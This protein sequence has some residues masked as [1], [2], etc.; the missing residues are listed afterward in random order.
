MRLH[1]PTFASFLLLTAA[2]VAHADPNALWNIVHGKCVVDTAP[3]VSVN[4]EEHFALLK[5]QRGV[6]QHLLI[7]TER[8]TGIEDKALLDPATP[9]FFAD[10][11][12]EKQAVDAK[13]PRP[14]HRDELSLAV[15]AQSARTQN[16]L[17]IHI[18]CLS[19]KAHDELAS[20]L[21]EIK[22]EWAPL[23]VEID[24]HHFMAERVMGETLG[25]YNPF[26][27]LAK[28]LKDPATEMAYQNL[29]VVG[30][31]FKEGPGFIILTDTAFPTTTGMAGGEDLQDHS[32]AIDKPA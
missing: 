9:N 6:A 8:I 26:L 16:Q 18:D 3:C 14:L 1:L 29:D 22:P 21:D 19:T 31:Y 30:A 17:H 15:N 5:D 20:V 13:L 12:S 25:N 32:C 24:G 27:A 28:T 2:P 11:W 7:P 23:P 10:A 4:K